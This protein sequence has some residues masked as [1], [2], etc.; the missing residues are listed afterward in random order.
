[1]A[2]DIRIR[3]LKARVKN[4][5]DLTDAGIMEWWLTPNAAFKDKTP[6]E[7]AENPKTLRQMEQIVNFSSSDISANIKMSN[8]R[9]GVNPEFGF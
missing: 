7:M 4:F 5:L 1:M 9:R 8:P 2:D 3:K 6:K